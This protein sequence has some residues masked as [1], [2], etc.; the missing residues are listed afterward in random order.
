MQTT[1]SSSLSDIQD[2]YDLTTNALIL[3]DSTRTSL[4]IKRGSGADTD[5]LLE[6]QN[7]AGTSNLVVN[8]NG[9]ITQATWNGAVVGVAY[10]GT[11][12][13]SYTTGDIIYAS[14]STTLSKLAAAASGNALLSGTT[15]SWGKI[16]LTTHVSGTLPIANG[17][18]NSSTALNNNR[19]MESNGGAIVERAAMTNGQLIIGSTG[20]NPASAT[21]TPGDNQVVSNG[22]GSITINAIR[23]AEKVYASA[24]ARTT[25][26][27][28]TYQ[29]KLSLV[30][31]TLVTANTYKLEFSAVL[32]S[33]AANK[34]LSF[35]INNST[36]AVVVYES[37]TMRASAT[38]QRISVSG[39]VILT[40]G[41]TDAR[42]FQMQWNSTDNST[43]IGIRYAYLDFYRIA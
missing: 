27:S 22:A 36:D 21:L 14:A 3:T 8:A 35:R 6:L 1:R 26:T 24:A 12:I 10:G 2:A 19:I 18:T 4:K 37:L 38:N 25:T 7:A 34:S 40:F 16:G 32:D 29:T 41:T 30:T 9:V 17:G 15:P 43:T 31:G 20:A 42:T 33:A 39:F 11:G 5:N 23:G 28:S 13:A